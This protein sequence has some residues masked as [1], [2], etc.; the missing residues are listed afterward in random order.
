[1]PWATIWA[2]H[3]IG[4]PSASAARPAAPAPGEATRSSTRSTMPHEWIMRT[5]TFSRS[6]GTALRSASA[7][8][9]AKDR[10]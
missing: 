5:A 3:R 1:M 7:R 6:G 10:S 8:M 2:S 9:M 4:A